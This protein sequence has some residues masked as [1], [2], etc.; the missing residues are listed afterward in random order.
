MNNKNENNFKKNNEQEK[1]NKE[2]NFD[3]LGIE[4]EIID[5]EGYD[6]EQFLCRCSSKTSDQIC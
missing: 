2:F 6:I 5:E 4:F 3:D 1:D